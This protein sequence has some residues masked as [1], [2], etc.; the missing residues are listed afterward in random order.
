MQTNI[1]K[2]PHI[3]SNVPG[4]LLGEPETI[5][6]TNY[7]SVTNYY[8]KP[9]GPSDDTTDTDKKEN[10]YKIFKYKKDLLAF[11]LVPTYGLLRSVIVNSQNKVVSFAPPKS[12]AADT[13][14]NMYPHKTEDVYA[15]DFIEGTMF[16][17]FFDR[18]NCWWRIATR[19]TIDPKNAFYMNSG[20]E[21]KSFNDMFN[22]ACAKNNSNAENLNL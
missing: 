1:L 22:D 15:E 8:S 18:P 2:L 19:S 11:D 10:T 20:S 5:T 6:E 3:L 13:F 16:N 7:F 4:F 14:M 9:F 12:I 17:V 21:K